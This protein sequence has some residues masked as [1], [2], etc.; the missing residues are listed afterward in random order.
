MKRDVKTQLRITTW[1]QSPLPL[2]EIRRVPSQLDRERGVIVP[3]LDGWDL[4]SR[5]EGEPVFLTGETYLHLRQVRLDDADAIH[6]FVTRFGPL[7]GREASFE[8]SRSRNETLSRSYPSLSYR[9]E[10]KNKERALWAAIVQAHPRAA[11]LDEN[12]RQSLLLRPLRTTPS[13]V[14]TLTEFRYAATCLHDLTDA[15]LALRDREDLSSLPWQSLRDRS[16]VAANAANA[17]SFF[18]TTLDLFLK[19]FSPQI[20]LAWSFSRGIEPDELERMFQP[21]DSMEVLA[22]RDTRSAPLYAIC[23]LEL[24]NHIVGDADYRE[25]ANERCRRTFSKQEGRSD[26][27]QHRSSGVIYCS[28]SCARATAQRG[29]RRRQKPLSAGDFSG[30]RLGLHHEL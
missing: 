13:P 21:T 14:E 7:G 1:P 12:V 29:Y 20:E 15:W 2:P 5:F 16:I 9:R 19:R 23:A 10:H 3:Q 18:S 8:L 6:R 28:A 22:V 17:T 24:F 27:G 26:K 30:V 25:C 11:Q 4:F